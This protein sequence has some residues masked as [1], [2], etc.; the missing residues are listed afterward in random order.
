[1]KKK[2]K[3]V[4]DNYFRSITEQ[5]KIVSGDAARKQKKYVY[6]DILSFLQPNTIRRE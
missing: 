2:W 4:K 6:A 5:K 1:L 3:N